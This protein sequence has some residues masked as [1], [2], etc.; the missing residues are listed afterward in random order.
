LPYVECDPRAPGAQPEHCKRVDVRGYPTWV[1]GGFRHE[2]VMTLDELAR[3][4]GFL[5]PAPQ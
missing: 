5:W 1:L 2:G 3:A 4:S